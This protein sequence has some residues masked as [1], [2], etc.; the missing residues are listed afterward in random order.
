MPSLLNIQS[1]SSEQNKIITSEVVTN[2][3]YMLELQLNFPKHINICC[4]NFIEVS[5]KRKKHVT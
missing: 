1:S 4:C 5:I 2:P 3:L